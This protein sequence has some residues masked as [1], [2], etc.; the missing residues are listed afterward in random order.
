MPQRLCATVGSVFEDDFDSLAEIRGDNLEYAYSPTHIWVKEDSPETFK[1]GGQFSYNAQA[2]ALA[3]SETP[4]W[5]T[6][7][8]DK[9]ETPEPNSL[10][11]G[12]HYYICEMWEV[13]C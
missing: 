1:N 8:L 10:K 4:E 6:R 9:G 11:R 7:M 13:L 12:T 5:A 2:R 3:R